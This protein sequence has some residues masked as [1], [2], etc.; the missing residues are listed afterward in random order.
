MANKKKPET[1]SKETEIEITPEQIV[2]MAG[3]GM[4]TVMSI[5]L[6]EGLYLEDLR[7]RLFYLD[8]EVNAGLLHKVTMEIYKINGVDRGIPEEKRTPIML[9]INSCG[10]DVL[11]GTGLCDAIL[12]S[13]TPV[14][15][16]CAGYAMS[17][18]FAIFSVCHL[19]VAMPNS[20]GMY[21]DGWEYM[22]NTSTK[23]QDW[24]KFSPKLDRRINKMIAKHS[25]FTVKRLEKIAPHDSYWFADELAE[26]GIVDAIIGKDIEMEDLFAFMSDGCCDDEEC[27]CKKKK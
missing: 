6:A 19:R 20:I 23:A 3:G 1:T 2:E 17:M 18:A 16:V 12:Q 4:Q 14:L 13:K 8:G 15:G 11:S 22:E 24:S 10:G 27:D 9:V 25:K 26:L 21:H 7:N 5:G